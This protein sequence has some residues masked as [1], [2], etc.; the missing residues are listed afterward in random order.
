[1][2]TYLYGACKL[3]LALMIAFPVM[4][5]GYPAAYAAEPENDGGWSTN[6]TGWAKKEGDDWVDE[7]G[8]K[9]LASPGKNT[10]MLAEGMRGSLQYEA[11]LTLK[12]MNGHV[13]LVFRANSNGWDSYK[14]QLE[15]SKNEIRLVGGGLFQTYAPAEALELNKA[16]SVRIVAEESRIQVFFGSADQ[17][18]FDLENQTY[19][20]GQIGILVWDSD[21]LI[22]NAY[23]EDIIPVE[24]GF[25][26]N[27]TG[28]SYSGDAGQHNDSPE[29]LRMS[30][31][32]NYFALAEQEMEHFVLD[33]D[34]SFEE[35]QGLGSIVFRSGDNGWS[36]YM[37]QLDPAADKIRLVNANDQAPG[38]LYLEAEAEIRPNTAYRI[39]IKSDGNRLSLFW[40]G[41]GEPVF[42]VIDN[43]HA[44]GRIG[45]HVYNGT[46][47]F[48]NVTVRQLN[49]GFAEVSENLGGWT[50]N[51]D[52]LLEETAEGLKLASQ[53]NF[54]AISDRIAGD[55]AFEAD[56]RLDSFE[57]L[58]SLVFRS[59]Q[60]GWRSY[61]LQ[62][63]TVA[64]SP[65]TGVLRLLNAD[66]GAANRLFE[67]ES[68]ALAPAGQFNH[69]KVVARG[70][71]LQVFWNGGEEPLITVTDSSYA[72]GRLGLHVY[73]GSAVFQHIFLDGLSETYPDVITNL[74]GWRIRENGTVSSS[75]NSLLLQS[76]SHVTA[77]AGTAGSDFVYESDLTIESD[78]ASGGLILRAD[79]A[80]RQGYLVQ[81]DHKTQKLRLFSLDG[82]NGMN[83][84]A[85]EPIDIEAGQTYR[86]RVTA[87]QSKLQV[88]WNGKYDPVLEAVSGMYVSGFLGL[89]AYEGSVRFQNIK[90][91]G[92]STNVT[93]WQSYGGSW[94][95]HLNGLQGTQ[96]GESLSARMA[97]AP[98]P[99]AN[100]RDKV[101][102]ADLILDEN[103][104][105]AAAG[106]LLHANEDGT[107][108][109]LLT[110]GPGNRVA[111]Q[112]REGN[113]STVV[114][115]SDSIPL[116]PGKPHH[117]EIVA[118]GSRITAYVDGYETPAVDA[119]GLNAEQDNRSFGIAVTG[120]TA[121]FQNVYAYDLKS[122]YEELY[123]P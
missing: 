73:D 107:E 115:A 76:D 43:A 82:G 70:S 33:A 2:R 74:E 68:V 31:A 9:R 55:F 19:G 85:E 69:L 90:V 78:G 123:R 21:V 53:G 122:Y 114:S 83:W 112:K 109:Y 121:Y 3:I 92:M 106:L 50:T 102:E 8:G 95:P 66:D 117:I 93:E 14:V 71:S 13:S 87:D 56:V 80:G 116:A 98:S 94:K 67:E 51:E 63:V 30:S 10:M 39:R 62:A 41:S 72:S 118:E 4:Y 25:R 6:M 99:L 15:P 86:L 16:Y 81:A 108:G 75:K 60:S 20:S 89:H 37:V 110:I 49:G 48:Q 97:E 35:E 52:G 44:N 5:P 24:P 58:A 26:T 77:L 111:L 113:A 11:D 96:E 42:S 100:T 29:G 120:G 65:G 7:E 64:S 105:N 104:P 103:T 101:L 38:R 61:M 18:I 88:Y 1:M 17:P 45:M 40:N 79:S 32:G 36:S 28:W 22:R 23:A 119:S 47:I 57:G 84:L 46:A 12:N 91:S 34:V 27:L 59:D 54:F